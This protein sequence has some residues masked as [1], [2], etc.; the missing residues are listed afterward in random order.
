MAT[1]LEIRAKYRRLRESFVSG[2]QTEPMKRQLAEGLKSLV[3]PSDL[4]FGFVATENEADPVYAYDRGA[5]A[6]PRVEGEDIS[7]YLPN[8]NKKGFLKSKWGIMEPDPGHSQKVKI[9][10]A[11]GILVPGVAFDVMGGR[12]G[13]GKGFY[14]RALK[15]YRGLKVGV[16]Y[17]VQVTDEELP[18]ENFDVTMDYLVTEDRVLVIQKG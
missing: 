1:K 15:N 3:N 4:W 17:S 6:F 14:D 16:A 7:F 11:S 18:T 9:E 2:A 10:Q 13:S 12:V 8:E 5:W